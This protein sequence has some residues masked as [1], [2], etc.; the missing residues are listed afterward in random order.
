M[1][2][3]LYIVCSEGGAQDAITA[4][5][6]HFDVLERITFSKSQAVVAEPSRKEVIPV[7]ALPLQVVSVWLATE[8][9]HGKDFEHEFVF[10]FSLENQDQIAGKGTFRFTKPRHRFTMN[11]RGVYF[12]KEGTFTVISR[13]REV[14]QT[15][16]L[17]QDYPIEVVEGGATE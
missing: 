3:P 9:D 4:R 16:W 6:S 7:Q 1:A 15:A 13:I 10:R 12:G 17:T 14:G 2:R 5:V 8:E 11:A